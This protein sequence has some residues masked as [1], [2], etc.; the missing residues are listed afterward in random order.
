M[1]VVG[2]GMREVGVWDVGL[3]GALCVEWVCTACEMYGVHG[4]WGAGCGATGYG[5]WGVDSL[6]TQGVKCEI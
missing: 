3:R 4:L 2:R 5:V 1:R 6:D